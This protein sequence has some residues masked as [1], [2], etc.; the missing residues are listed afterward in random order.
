MKAVLFDAGNTLLHLDYPWLARLAAALGAQGVEP[1]AVGRAVAA[2][3]R[4][5]WP[6]ASALDGPTAFVLLYFAAIGQDLGLAHAAAVRFAEAAQAEH[7]RHP[8]GLWR[9]PAPDAAAVLQALGRRGLRLGVVSNAD[10]RVEQQIEAA[11]LRPLVAVVVDSMLAGVEKPDPRIFHIALASLGVAAEDAL[12]VGDI[13]QFDVEGALRAGLKAILYDPWDAFPERT[14]GRI[15]TL[16]A[17][18]APEQGLRP[19]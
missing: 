16:S 4:R 2:A 19:D 18:L 5:E 14:E 13:P 10:G 8:L 6:R 15:R 17:L 3:G 12:Y 11:G 9:H 1:D 7:V